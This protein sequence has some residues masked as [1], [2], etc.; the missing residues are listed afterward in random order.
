[1]RLAAPKT[2]LSKR[3]TYQ[4]RI[5][6]KKGT[7]AVRNSARSAASCLK[8]PPSA[9]VLVKELLSITPLALTQ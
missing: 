5:N 1:V 3:H 8:Q 7:Q 2:D 6:A 4:K 9:L